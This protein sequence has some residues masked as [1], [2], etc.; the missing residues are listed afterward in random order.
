[1]LQSV[2]VGV[3]NGCGSSFH[4]IICSIALILTGQSLWKQ[5]LLHM[6]TLAE[7]YGK[8]VLLNFKRVTF[9]V[10]HVYCVSQNRSFLYLSSAYVLCI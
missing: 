4:K 6:Y 10:I 1:M 8:N 9:A 5:A 2:H 7:H 3:V